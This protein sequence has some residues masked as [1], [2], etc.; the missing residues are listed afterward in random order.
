MQLRRVIK[1]A[2]RWIALF[3]LIL[4]LGCSGYRFSQTS[5]PLAQ[6]GVDTL[7]IPMFYN[8]SSLPETSSTFTRET[9]KLLSGFTG[10]KLR[11]GWNQSAD[12]I[13]IGIIR[14]DD[15]LAQ[16][17]KS[18]SPR[19]AQ[20]VTPDLLK[21]SRPEFYVPGSSTVS[22][23]LQVIVIKRPTT[24]ELQLLQSDMGPQIPTS[25]KI[26]FNERFALASSFTREFFDNEAGVVAATQNAGA[27][28]RTKDAMGIQAAELI[29]DMILYAF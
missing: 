16:T 26:I 12:A 7:S 20:S 25:A 5:N 23:E 24:E 29:R 14:S 8:F 11:S 2:M 9:Y 15:S 10:L 6:Y 18:Q 19:V 3:P 1:K 13:L 22:L 21:D 27:L 17:V 28:R 4:L